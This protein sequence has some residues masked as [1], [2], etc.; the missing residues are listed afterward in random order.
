[1]LIVVHDVIGESM[2]VAFHDVYFKLYSRSGSFFNDHCIFSCTA[3]A[4]CIR[5][6]ICESAKSTRIH[7]NECIAINVHHIVLLM[8]EVC[9]HGY[10]VL[11]RRTPTAY[12][13]YV[14][15]DSEIDDLIHRL[16]ALIY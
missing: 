14:V 15:S 5:L 8:N 6:P 4:R 13:W 7:C 10:H 11:L 16:N 9:V 3:R 2:L 1:M 12:K